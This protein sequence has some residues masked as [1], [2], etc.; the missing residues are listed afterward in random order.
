MQP[1]PTLRMTLPNRKATPRRSALSQKLIT[2]S[3]GPRWRGWCCASSKYPRCSFGGPPGPHH[4][5]LTRTG[6]KLLDQRTGLAAILL[7]ML[8]TAGRPASA[9]DI[10]E[11]RLDRDSATIGDRIGITLEFEAPRDYRLGPFEWPYPP[12]T[13]FSVGQPTVVT[14]GD[15]SW[16]VET[17]VVLFATGVLAAG[18]NAVLLYGP[19]GDS[20]WVLFPPE[21]VT[22]ASVLPAEADS[23]ALE[24][25]DFKDIVIPPWRPPLWLWVLAGVI[26]AA[27][28]AAW[29]IRRR[30]RAPAVI[31]IVPARPPW[32]V[33]L[34]QLDALSARGYH[35]RGEARPFAI[36]LSEIL[37]GY[38]E[39]RYGM[40]AL[41][42][43]N[44]EIRRALAYVH[45][46]DAQRDEVMR[47][48]TGCDFAKYAHFRWPTGE[49]GTALNG[50]QRFVEDTVPQPTTESIAS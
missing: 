22:V 50:T 3:A 16:R 29:W 46:T 9:G 38:L 43:T 27:V 33:A 11:V 4:R 32:E 48:L 45:L 30:R 42:Q 49:L 37:R 15:S 1:A 10:G 26:V 8:I 23:T 47:I 2:H 31:A 5:I 36:A 28:L 41:E 18:P 7:L 35:D 25:A 6:N 17:E 34:E 13:T 44:S 19:A 14:S 21:T 39:H 40:L 12:D 20:L 24:T